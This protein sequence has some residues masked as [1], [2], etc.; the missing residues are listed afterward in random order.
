PEEIRVRN[1]AFAPP[2][3]LLF[4]LDIPPARGLQRVR[5]R[6]TLSHF[7]RLDYLARVAAIFAAM[8]F[9]YLRHI[10]ASSEPALVQEQVWQATAPLLSGVAT[11]C[12]HDSAPDPATTQEEG[13][14]GAP[15]ADTVAGEGRADVSG[16]EGKGDP[17]PSADAVAEET[18]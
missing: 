9:P 6:G 14:A 5:Q 11:R 12:G 18:A 13:R 3:D 10:D 7:E 1:E 17:K 8:Q 15:S 2:P 4:I 16:R